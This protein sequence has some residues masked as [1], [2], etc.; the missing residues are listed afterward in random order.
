MHLGVRE[1]RRIQYQPRILREAN[2][3]VT[4]SLYAL[5]TSAASDALHSL[6]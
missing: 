3:S 1:S 4:R 5:L 2:A 6:A